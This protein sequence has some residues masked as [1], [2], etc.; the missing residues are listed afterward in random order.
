MTAEAH[1]T[2]RF[3]LLLLLVAGAMYGFQDNVAEIVGALAGLLE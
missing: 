1:K 2:L 3:I